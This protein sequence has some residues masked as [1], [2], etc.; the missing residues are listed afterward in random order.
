MSCDRDWLGKAIRIVEKQIQE[1]NKK[2]RGNYFKNLATQAPGIR[3]M[4]STL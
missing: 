3:G 2:Q 4:V 1:M